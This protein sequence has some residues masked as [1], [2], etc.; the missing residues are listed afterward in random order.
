MTSRVHCFGFNTAFQ[1]ELIGAWTKE[2][3]ATCV[4]VVRL[5]TK[6][7]PNADQH[8][9]TALR[10]ARRIPVGNVGTQVKRK[11]LRLQYN[12]LFRHLDRARPEQVL[13][14]NGLNGVNYLVNAVCKELELPTLYFERAPLQDRLQIDS[15]GVNYLSSVPRNR[16]FYL[17]LPSDR[18]TTVGNSEYLTRYSTEQSTP[19]AEQA[20][21]RADL[22]S[23]PYLFCPLQ[24]PRDTQITVFGGWVKSISY[25]LGCVNT[26]SL[27]LAEGFKIRIKEHP[28]SPIS[29]RDSIK[30][31]NNPNLICDIE[32]D[33]YD[34]L[35]NSKGVITINS[36]VGLEAFSFQVPVLTLGKALYS[37]DGLT[38]RISNLDS[39]CKTLAKVPRLEWSQD[40]R[41]RFLN[42]LYFWF[43]TKESVLSGT[44]TPEDLAQ[45]DQVFADLD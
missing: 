36:S 15:N 38:N 7:A 25:F 35:A 34:L 18:F 16:D 27:H 32:H 40:E 37:F 43:P 21:A 5:S 2:L 9:E 12:W 8:T 45:R 10:S 11:F 31:F 19:A 39:F 13:I 30:S 24:V 44:Y 23:V 4:D 6:Q 42:F 14:Y 22:R 20:D 33:V 26:A 1:R 28:S 3:D 41:E 17:N 29:F